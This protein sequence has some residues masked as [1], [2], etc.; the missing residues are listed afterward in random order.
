M[1]NLKITKIKMKSNKKILQLILISSIFLTNLV[2]KWYA[3][4][5]EN[6][7]SQNYLVSAYYSPLPNQ[8]MYIRWSYEND[9]VLNWNWTNWADWT[10]VYMWLLAAPKTY[11]F[12]TKV[13]LPWIW[14]WT[15][16]D[17]W[18]AIVKWSN[19][20][21]I[22]IW[23]W[24]WEEWLSRAL[25]WWMRFIEWKKCSK[26]SKIAD[27]LDYTKISWKLPEFVESRLVAKSQWNKGYESSVKT[28]TN[29]SYIKKENKEIIDEIYQ[30]VK[31]PVDLWEWDKWEDVIKLQ[32]ILQNLWYYKS[33]T[34]S[35][36]YDVNTIEAV[37]EFQ[38]ENDIL[39]DNNELWAWHFWKK[40][41]KTLD[42]Y[43]IKLYKI[44]KSE[45]ITKIWEIENIW[46]NTEES[47]SQITLSNNVSIKFIPVSKSELFEEDNS[48]S[49]RNIQLSLESKNKIDTEKLDK[50][51][52]ASYA[53]SDI[54]TKIME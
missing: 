30:F 54:K 14:I 37:F 39:W 34:L 21:R 24:K 7:V 5:W 40:T 26:N 29:T 28:N 19:Y 38:R 36:N 18:W 35:W 9:V 27:T 31:I 33:E 4:D 51:I 22:D 16:H 20:D 25:N 32:M 12:W 8:K 46:N 48:K 3:D 52:V 10:E 2:W 1:I 6:C 44:S 13:I 17:R 53:S 50:S 23:M 15:V 41:K 42:D 11:E 45:I 47:K 43:L 49:V